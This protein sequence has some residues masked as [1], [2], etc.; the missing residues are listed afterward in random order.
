MISGFLSIIDSILFA[1]EYLT[2]QA[3]AIAD[4]LV[5]QSVNLSASIVVKLVEDGLETC[6]ECRI[7][8][9]ASRAA[10]VRASAPCGRC[11]ARC[12]APGFPRDAVRAVPLPTPARVLY[13]QR[14]IPILGPILPA[15][16]PCWMLFPRFREAKSAQTVDETRAHPLRLALMGEYSSSLVLCSRISGL[17]QRVG[18]SVPPWP[19]S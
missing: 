9:E 14:W 13:A 16:K 10:A 8:H 5:I 11:N 19:R 6:L 17:I 18:L 4:S 2:R 15:L 3:V 7:H 1:Y 12:V